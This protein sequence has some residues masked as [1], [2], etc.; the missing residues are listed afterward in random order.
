M[1]YSTDAVLIENINFKDHINAFFTDLFQ[2][3]NTENINDEGNNYVFAPTIIIE[4]T[5]K[6]ITS[7]VYSTYIPEKWKKENITAPTLTCKK[8]TENISHTIY[9]DYGMIPNRISATIEE[10]IF[11]NYK[12]FDNSRILS[13]EVYNDL[14][15]AAILTE[16][17]SIIKTVDIINESFTEII[18]IFKEI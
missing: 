17:K 3:E 1:N 14:D 5:I 7:L 2:K 8:I 10:G 6:H 15:I 9:R 11:I 16:G 4:P 13:I 18:K 12:N